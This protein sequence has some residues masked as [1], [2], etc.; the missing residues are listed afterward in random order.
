VPHNNLLTSI[1]N[2]MG[3]SDVKTFGIP[4]VCTGPL[5]SPALSG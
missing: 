2:A 4:G 1:C 5:A 3:L